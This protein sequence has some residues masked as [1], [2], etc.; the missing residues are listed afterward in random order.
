MY[1]K[2]TLV[3]RLGGDPEM[4]YL[5]DGKPVTNFSL[6]TNRKWSDRQSGDQREETIWWRVSVFGNQA[7]AC[8][9]YLSKGRQ[10]LVEGR[11][12][13]DPNSGG[14][15]I[16]TRQDGTPAASYEMT[17]S[18]VQFLGGRQEGGAEGYSAAPD[19]AEVDA[20]GIPF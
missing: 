17:A 4:R 6:A 1:Q 9:Q 3:G 10:V 18:V 2:I 16:W 5:A 14:P 8:N 19:A 20:D 12:R 11:M 13:P 15:R 7:E